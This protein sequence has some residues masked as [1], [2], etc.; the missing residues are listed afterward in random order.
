MSHI[1]LHKLIRQ[2]E[3]GLQQF[4]ISVNRSRVVSMCLP[5]LTTLRQWKLWTKCV[6]QSVVFLFEI[7]LYNVA[8]FWTIRI[9]LNIGTWQVAFAFFQHAPSKTIVQ[10]KLVYFHWVFFDIYRLKNFGRANVS[11]ICKT[12]LVLLQ[13][14]W[15]LLGRQLLSQFL[16]TLYVYCKM[17]AHCHI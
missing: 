12:C 9:R 16:S 1:N 5:S 11:I 4:S 6:F 7:V 17:F 15:A 13:N 2:N 8:M 14:I 3:E 10:H